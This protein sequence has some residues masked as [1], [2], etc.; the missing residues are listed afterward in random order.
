MKHKIT[1]AVSILFAGQVSAESLD[2]TCVN[3]VDGS[4][5]SYTVDFSRA[6]V[7]SK[8]TG[9]TTKAVID[10]DMIYFHEEY[11]SDQLVLAVNINRATGIMRISFPGQPPDPNDPPYKC[12]K[13]KTLF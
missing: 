1:L 3:Q 4:T 6:Q 13:S 10:S 7:T 5:S 2:L 8:S 12:S 11:P 9:I